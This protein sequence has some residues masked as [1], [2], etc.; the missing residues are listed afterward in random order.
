M[1][2][3]LGRG[4]SQI[5]AHTC[6]A[7]IEWGE[8]VPFLFPT[9]C[10]DP[11]SMTTGRDPWDTQDREPGWFGPQSSHLQGTAKTGEERIWDDQRRMLSTS[12]FKRGFSGWNEG[13]KRRRVV[14]DVFSNYKL[15]FQT[16]FWNTFLKIRKVKWENHNKSG[17]QLIMRLLL[18]F[19]LA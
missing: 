8:Q 11:L 10:S 13:K 6:P 9:R 18:L 7:R 2:E 17:S 4:Q 14:E 16:T 1:R 15:S 5:L 12:N 3:H 19:M